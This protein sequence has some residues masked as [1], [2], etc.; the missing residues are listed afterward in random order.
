MM[1]DQHDFPCPQFSIQIFGYIYVFLE[2]FYFFKK[3]TENGLFQTQP[4][5]KFG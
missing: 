5:T 4:L 1:C 2:H 3:K